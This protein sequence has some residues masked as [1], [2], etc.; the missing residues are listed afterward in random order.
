[1]N[2]EEALRRRLTE[3]YRWADPPDAVMRSHP[4]IPDGLDADADR[5]LQLWIEWP[6]CPPPALPQMRILIGIRVAVAEFQLDDL[7]SAGAPDE[8]LLAEADGPALELWLK[9]LLIGMWPTYRACWVNPHR[10]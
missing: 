5:L 4:P 8:M 10:N 1:M 6:G 9:Q 2:L 7:A 3:C